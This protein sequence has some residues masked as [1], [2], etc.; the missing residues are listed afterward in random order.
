M[1][2]FYPQP[3]YRESKIHLQEVEMMKISVLKT[4]HLCLDIKTPFIS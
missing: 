4:F 3:I 1:A 2:G